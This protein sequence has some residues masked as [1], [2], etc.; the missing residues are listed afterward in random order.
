MTLHGRILESIF[1]TKRYFKITFQVGEVFLSQCKSFSANCT[2]FNSHRE[3][4][5]SLPEKIRATNER[6]SLPGKVQG[7]Q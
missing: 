5:R 2:S 6:R 4:E 7:D 1:L 3:A